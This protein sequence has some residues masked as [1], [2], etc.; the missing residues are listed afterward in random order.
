MSGPLHDAVEAFVAAVGHDLATLATTRG[1]ATDRVRADV[2]V[3]VAD[4]VAAFIDADAHHTDEELASYLAVIGPRMAGRMARATPDGLRRAGVL[5]GRRALLGHPSRVFEVLVSADRTDDGDRAWRYL[6]AATHVGQAVAAL[7][8]HTSQVELDALNRFRRTLLTAMSR[9][10]VSPPSTRQPDGGFFPV[11]GSPAPSVRAHHPGVGELIALQRGELE[12]ADQIHRQ[13]RTRTSGEPPSQIEDVLA[14]LEAL[15]GLEPVKAEVE[16]VTNLLVVQQ[17][18]ERRGLPTVPMSRHL[19]FTGNPGTG[20]TT[21]ARLVGEIYR[22]LGVIT[23]GHLVETDRSGM[24]AGYVGQTAERTRGLVESALDGVLLIDEAYALARGEERDFG[25]EAIDT[26]VK[27]MED[28][29]DRL[30]VIVAGYPDEMVTFIESNPGLASRFP[31]TIHFPDYSSDELVAIARHTADRAGYRFDEAALTLLASALDTMP[32][33]AGF[34]N[35]RLVRNLFEAAV[36]QHASRLVAQGRPT[37][38]DLVTV[39]ADD[40]RDGLAAVA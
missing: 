2:D 25:R 23:G 14:E 34:G 5:N 19:V 18:R 3:E 9:A 20:K 35:A 28:H 22:S 36:A 21:V 13:V 31:R 27:M 29:R 11:E 12:P 7:D 33:A 8:L 37:D 24:V 30:V 6:K 39:T 17:L 26:L 1:L 10:G 40:L 4:L 15:I 16:L 38:D 32:R